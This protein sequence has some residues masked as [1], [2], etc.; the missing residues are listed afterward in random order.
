MSPKALHRGSA[1]KREKEHVGVQPQQDQSVL[2]PAAGQDPGPRGPEPTPR[3]LQ[4]P[5]QA[6]SLSLKAFSGST[7]TS[8]LHTQERCT[9]CITPICCCWHLPSWRS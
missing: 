9:A 8:P 7:V 1:F 5:E 3:A 4:I 2:G 6:S